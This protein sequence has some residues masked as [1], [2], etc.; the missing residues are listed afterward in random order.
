MVGRKVSKEEE[1]HHIIES[2][3]DGQHILAT[4]VFHESGEKFKKGVTKDEGMFKHY[5]RHVYLI[6]GLVVGVNMF[7]KFY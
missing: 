5:L 1:Q 3:A 4:E 2:A 6:L 7:I